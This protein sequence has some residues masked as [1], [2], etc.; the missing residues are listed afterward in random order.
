MNP[1]L[2]KGLNIIQ[3]IN[4]V[5]LKIKNILMLEGK[6]LYYIMNKTMKVLLKI[7]YRLTRPHQNWE[8]YTEYQYNIL[9]SKTYNQIEKEIIILKYE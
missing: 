7:F 8:Y 1:Y 5:F 2:I 3:N 4:G 6:L 9:K